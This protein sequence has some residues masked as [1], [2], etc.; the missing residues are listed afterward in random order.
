MNGKFSSLIAIILPLFFSA[1][2]LQAMTATEALE[3]FRGRMYGAGAVTG[4]ISW[5]YEDSAPYTGSF[6]YLSP[7]RIHVKFSS[8][9]GKVLVSNGRKLWVYDPGTNI[10]G[11]QDLDGGSSGGIAGLVG[12]YNGIV[13]GGG[14]GYTLKLR[15]EVGA[16]PEITLMLDSTFFLKKAILKDRSGKSLRFTISGVDT[17]ATLIRTMFDFNPPANAQLIKNPLEVK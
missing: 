2:A 1:A 3:K 12:G 16:Y 15:N 11:V 8:P 5:S 4:T 17:S 14:G 10:C 13:T 9:S 6:K 7:G